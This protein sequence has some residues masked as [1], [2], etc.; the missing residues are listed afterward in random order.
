MT[1][2]P[3]GRGYMKEHEWVVFVDQTQE[4]CTSFR[5]IS[6]WLGLSHRATYD[7]KGL[8]HVVELYVR[9]ET[10]VW[11]RA[12]RP[13]HTSSLQPCLASDPPPWLLNR[14]PTSS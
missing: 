10:A 2:K 7:G 11:N 5:L 4:P 12:G 9:E 1:R 8:G 13:G 14:K 6:H 3:D